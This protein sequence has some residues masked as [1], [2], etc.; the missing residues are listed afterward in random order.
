M[1]RRREREECGGSMTSVFSEHSL[2][3]LLFVLSAS[4][5][6]RTVRRTTATAALLSWSP[7]LFSVT[8][9]SISMA[10][11]W[12]GRSS[13]SWK[14]ENWGTTCT[15]MEFLLTCVERRY[16]FNQVMYY[17]LT[18]KPAFQLI[19]YFCEGGTGRAGSLSAGFTVWFCCWH[20]NS[21]KP[22]WDY[23]TAWPQ[24]SHH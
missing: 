3:Q 4:M 9:V 19:F 12:S 17:L 16:F 24:L 7:A 14:W 22:W 13:W 1:G 15:Y 8:P 20:P 2:E 5:F 6:V 11:C 10:T 21:W 18:L 23:H